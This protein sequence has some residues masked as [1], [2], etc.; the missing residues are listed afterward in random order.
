MNLCEGGAARIEQPG[1][2]IGSFQIE[3]PPA[4]GPSNADRSWPGGRLGVVTSHKS[5]A[6][7]FRQ[8]QGGLAPLIFR[9]CGSSAKA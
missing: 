1:A 3:R 4:A 9:T 2:M 5:E 7:C 6:D 8:L